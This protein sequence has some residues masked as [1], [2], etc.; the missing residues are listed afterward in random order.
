MNMQESV[1][2]DYDFREDIAAA[3]RIRAVVHSQPRP[4][5]CL[6]EPEEILRPY[7]IPKER[8]RL[9]REDFP[10]LL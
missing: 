7:L 8:E 5:V 9:L 1:E 10:E 6:R 4:R 2:I 3:E